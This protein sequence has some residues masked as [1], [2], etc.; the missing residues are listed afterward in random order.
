VGRSDAVAELHCFYRPLVQAH[1]AVN[2]ARHDRLE[3]TA[4]KSPALGSIPLLQ[5]PQ[6]IVYRPPV[7]RDPLEGRPGPAYAPRHRQTQSARYFT[8]STPGWLRGSSSGSSR[9]Q[10]CFNLGGAPAAGAPNTQLSKPTCPAGPA[11]RGGRGITCTLITC[12]TWAARRRAGVSRRLD[13]ATSRGKRR[14]RNRR[15]LSPSRPASRWRL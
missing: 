2:P 6:A 12:P 11:R 1:A 3:A 8:K 15:R 5:L 13:R 14:S 10:S 4:A 9:A 7:I